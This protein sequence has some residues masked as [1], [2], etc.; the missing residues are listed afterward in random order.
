VLKK[1][2][3]IWPYQVFQSERRDGLVSTLSDE[4][5]EE[6]P[7]IAVRQDCP[8]RGVALL[9]QPFVKEGVQ[10]LGQRGEIVFRH[11]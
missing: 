2:Q 5:E 3:H 6:T 10:Q 8:L 4:P 9:D 11:Q 1:G 7:R